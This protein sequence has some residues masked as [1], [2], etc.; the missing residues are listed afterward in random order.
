MFETTEENY[1]RI[2]HYTSGKHATDDI[3][4]EDV[5]SQTFVDMVQQRVSFPDCEEHQAKLY[6]QYSRWA[7]SHLLRERKRDYTGALEL[8]LLPTSKV[9]GAS[10]DHDV[11]SISRPVERAAERKE[12]NE[13]VRKELE[14]IL[15]LRSCLSEKSREIFDMRVQGKTRNEVAK[16]LGISPKESENYW[17]TGR[18]QI[19]KKYS[20]AMLA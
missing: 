9:V 12:N 20:D 5:I 4:R 15:S 10:E 18:K 13:R 7:R 19:V 16:E 1:Q 2:Y 11:S 17:Y 8:L 6:S 3:T 14:I